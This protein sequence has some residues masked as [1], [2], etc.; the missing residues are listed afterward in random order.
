MQDD[1]YMRQALRLAKKGMGTTSP[2]PMVGAV[3]VKNGKIVGRGYHKKKGSPHAEVL[4]LKSAG[5]LAKGSTLYTTLEPCIQFGATPPCVP[6]II[7]AGIK[8]VYIATLD[9]NPA[10]N[11][12]GVQK[13][14]CAGIKVEVGLCAEK[15]YRLNE[16][17]NKFITTKLPF[18]IL[19]SAI[20]LDGRIGTNRQITSEH[21]RRFAHRLRAEVDAVVVGI[22]TVLTDDPLLT[23][24]FVTGKSPKRLVL[25]TDFRIPESAKVMGDGCIIATSSSKKREISAEVWRLKK[26]TGMVDINSLLREAGKREITSI[27]VEGGKEVY[28][29]FLN[30]NLIDKFYI[31]IGAK[32]FGDGHLPFLNNLENEIEIRYSDVKMLGRDILITAYAVDRRKGPMQNAK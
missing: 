10:V 3:V 27:L 18:L 23:T 9:P 12:Q 8:K 16:V 22:N 25:D 21:G 14:L 4:A 32:M 11:G 30:R 24:R 26:D 13:L 1:Y 2:N 15:A 6:A 31:F 17:Y 19:K 5:E 29:S 28:T 20:T 7:G